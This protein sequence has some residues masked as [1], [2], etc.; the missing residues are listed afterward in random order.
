MTWQ[1]WPSYA[2]FCLFLWVVTAG[3]QLRPNDNFRFKI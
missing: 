3:A 2:D 1:Y